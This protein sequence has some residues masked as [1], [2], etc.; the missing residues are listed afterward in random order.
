MTSCLSRNQP[1]RFSFLSIG[2]QPHSSLSLQFFYFF[3]K[4]ILYKRILNL[5]YSH[6]SALAH[7]HTLHEAQVTVTGRETFEP[8]ISC[9][10]QICPFKV[11]GLCNQSNDKRPSDTVK[12]RKFDNFSSWIC[13][14]LLTKHPKFMVDRV[15]RVHKHVIHTNEQS[16]TQLQLSVS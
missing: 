8:N 12:I 10:L 13:Y 14:H 4:A 2:G 9:N 15:F 7:C 5:L 16:I 11:R 3:L 6:L 1:L